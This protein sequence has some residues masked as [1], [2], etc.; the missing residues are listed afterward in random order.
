M[1]QRLKPLVGSLFLLGVISMPAFAT[2]GDN[3]NLAKQVAELRAEVHDLQT[4]IALGHRTSKTKHRKTSKTATNASASSIEEPAMTTK[5]AEETAKQPEHDVNVPELGEMPTNG[6][7]YLP[8]DV[9]VPGQSF[10]SSGPYI[11]VP[12]QYSGGNLIVNAPSVNND[13]ALLKI[14]KNIHHRLQALGVTEQEDHAHVLLSGIV[15]GQA[16]YKDIGGGPDSS[17]IDLTNATLDAYILG[18]SAWL[19]SLISFTYD[20]TIGTDTGTF[21]NNSRVQNSRVQLRQGFV[22]IG[23]LSATPVYGTFGQFFVPFG[24]YASNMV[25]PPLTQL[26]ARTKQRAIEL[27]WQSPGEDAPYAAGYIFRGD[28]HVG[29]TSRVNNGGV[30]LG[31]RFNELGLRG[32]IGAGV[33]ANIADSSGMQFVNNSPTTFNGFGGVG[34]TGNENIAHR[35]PAYDL[36]AN[37]GLGD[38]INLI[39]EYIAASTNFSRGDL[40]MNSHGAKPQ[41][42]DVEAAYTFEFLSRPTSVALGYEMTKDALALQLPAQRYAIVANTSIWRDTLQSLEFRHDVNYGASNVASG[43]GVPAPMA[44]GK[45]DNI[46]TAQFD[47]YF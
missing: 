25:T 27:G 30:N 16:L 13:V 37:L 33:L 6:L 34:G 24:A 10:V 41:A 36:R 43:S 40:T 32:D 3:Q 35:V 2:T 45:P 39:G 46:V 23:N 15:E 28:T 22:T 11:G 17:D 18:P 7:M 8:V 19:S 4:Q 44:S 12:L 20:N 9:D 31:Y 14:R 38:H 26:M 47:V 29:S 1:K 42:L 5:A 21:N